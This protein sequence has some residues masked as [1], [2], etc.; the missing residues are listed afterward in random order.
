MTAS[1]L[2]EMVRYNN[3]ANQQLIAHCKTLPREVLERTVPG[4]YGTI[5]DT[6][7]HLIGMEGTFYGAV[8]GE[9]VDEALPASI[10]KTLDE[11]E[12]LARGIGGRWEEFAAN[13]GDI[14]RPV[15]QGR[16]DFRPP[17]ITALTQLICHGSEHRAQVETILGASGLQPPGFNPWHYAMRHPWAGSHPS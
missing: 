2:L 11:L 14:H 7:A 15:A 1:A 16:G 13:P 17:I 5:P 12:P 8:T 6:F 9:P 3:W 4:V 10:A